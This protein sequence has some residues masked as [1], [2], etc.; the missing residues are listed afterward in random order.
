ML[1]LLLPTLQ[2]EGLVAAGGAGRGERARLLGGRGGGRARMTACGDR[3][4]GLGTSLRRLR[5]HLTV[6]DLV[7]QAHQARDGLWQRR[8]GAAA[9][10]PRHRGPSVA[11]RPSLRRGVGGDAGAERLATSRSGSGRTSSSEWP[12]PTPPCRADD[13]DEALHQAHAFVRSALHAAGISTP[14]GNGSPSSWTAARLSR[15]SAPPRYASAP[16]H[17]AP[18]YCSRSSRALQLPSGKRADHL[19]PRYGP[20]RC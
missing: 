3:P 6:A 14:G 12:P 4:T 18:G 8:A 2:T 5:R 15:S 9:R 16:D 13:P 1:G 17:G 20:R 11:A 7:D 19:V 10:G